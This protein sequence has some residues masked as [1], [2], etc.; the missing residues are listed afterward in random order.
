MVW[1]TNERRLVLFP[2]GTIVRNP[3]HC[4]PL[5]SREQDLNLLRT[6]VQNLLNGAA[7]VGILGIFKD[8]WTG[9]FPSLGKILAVLD[10]VHKLSL[11]LGILLIFSKLCSSKCGGYYLISQLIYEVPHVP[12]KNNTFNKMFVNIWFGVTILLSD[13]V[14]QWNTYI[15]R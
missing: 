14:T 2:A 12:S 11:Y 6:W 13:L 8:Q 10:C 3:H 7:S 15:D 1:L 4:K 9:N 5:L